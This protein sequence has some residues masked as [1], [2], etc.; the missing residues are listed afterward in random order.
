MQKIKR[1]DLLATLEGLKGTGFDYLEKITAVDYVDHLEVDYIL[2]DVEKR[3]DEFL[4][5]DIDIN[6]AWV[7]TITH[8]FG[9][10]DWYEREMFEM[11]G[12]NVVGRKIGRILIEKWD[13]VDPPLRKSFKWN[14][15]YKSED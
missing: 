7:P 4:K 5:V 3:R 2:L 13:G 6:D 14:Q 8:I 11:F 9:G 10:A 15:P 12:I 1:E